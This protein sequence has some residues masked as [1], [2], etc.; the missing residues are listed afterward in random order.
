MLKH[1][2]AL[3]LALSA[4]QALAHEFN[5][6]NL[7]VDHPR[8]FETTDVAKSAAGYFAVL[9]KTDADDALLEIRANFPKVT[10]HNTIE[11]EG[12]DGGVMRMVP[13]D[14]MSIPDGDTITFAPGGLHVMFMGL[15]AP[16]KEGDLVPTTFVFQNA[17]E[18]DVIFVVEKA[19]GASHSGH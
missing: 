7:V 12:E 4:T 3:A 5:L 10:L 11:V 16:L 1:V 19:D 17:G 6:G 8:I 14:R 13:V 18:M 9:N 2:A 15:E